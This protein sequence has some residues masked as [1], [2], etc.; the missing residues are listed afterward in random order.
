MTYKN[1]YIL[2][3]MKYYKLIYVISVSEKK[4]INK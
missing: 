1:T 3:T 4:K 2:N